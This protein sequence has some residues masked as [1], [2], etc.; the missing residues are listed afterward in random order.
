VVGVGVGAKRVRARFAPDLADH[1]EHRRLIAVHT[2]SEIGS[3]ADG[4][5]IQLDGDIDKNW[6]AG[7]LLD[8]YVAS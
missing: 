1:T 4:H 3:D 8:S 5:L 7:E 2:W 6:R